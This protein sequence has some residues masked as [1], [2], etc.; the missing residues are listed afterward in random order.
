[1][2]FKDLISNIR[3]SIHYDAE[4]MAKKNEEKY[5]SNLPDCCRVNRQEN[6]KAA[7]KTQA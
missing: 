2:S 3:F 5:G 1:M 7:G 4:Q 6:E